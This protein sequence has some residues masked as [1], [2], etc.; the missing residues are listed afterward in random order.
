MNIYIY[1]TVSLLWQKDG[2]CKFIEM[3][4]NLFDVQHI[5]Y[6][7]CRQL[8]GWKIH[9]QLLGKLSNEKTSELTLQLLTV[10][11]VL[12]REYMYWKQCLISS[13]K[14]IDLHEYM[15]LNKEHRHS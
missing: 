6:E 5:V 1:I 11:V 3:R 4:F 14:K 8:I 10:H 2:W 13:H 9:C 15:G 7:K 12:C